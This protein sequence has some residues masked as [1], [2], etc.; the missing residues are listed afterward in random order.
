[1]D[2]QLAD[3]YDYVETAEKA[4]LNAGV[5]AEAVKAGGKALDKEMTDDNMKLIF[6]LKAAKTYL[7]FVMRRRDYK[8]V[9]SALN[10]AK[11]MLAVKVSDLDK[12]ELLLNTPCPLCNA[13]SK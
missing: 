7:A 3:A 1:M 13:Q 8:Y 4:L 6:M 12:N 10:A 11:P 5:S 2:L 9:V